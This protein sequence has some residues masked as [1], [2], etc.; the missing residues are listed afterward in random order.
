MVKRCA[1]IF[2]SPDACKKLRNSSR[3]ALRLK[4]P[5]RPPRSYARRKLHGRAGGA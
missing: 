2:L 5:R 3:S 4:I 1:E